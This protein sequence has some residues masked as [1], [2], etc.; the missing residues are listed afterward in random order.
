MMARY[1]VLFVAAI[2]LLSAGCISRLKWSLDP[3]RKQVEKNCYDEEFQGIDSD[4]VA[5]MAVAASRPDYCFTIGIIADDACMQEYY[6][7]KNDSKVCE[8]LPM[9]SVKQWCMD[10]FR[11]MEEWAK[12]P[13][14]EKVEETCA[15]AK[16]NDSCV[17]VDNGGVMP[18]YC[19]ASCV[20]DM[21]VAAAKPEYCYA[22]SASYRDYWCIE[23]YW[24]GM[25]NSAACETTPVISV[26]EREVCRAYYKDLKAGRNVD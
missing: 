10:D 9:S 4:C 26:P 2:L 6:E 22:L 3:E 21:A 7:I 14:K 15:A 1:A 11:H 20:A 18:N 25:N 8:S 5:K 23:L 13:E 16:E 19:Y 17:V 12:N 24:K